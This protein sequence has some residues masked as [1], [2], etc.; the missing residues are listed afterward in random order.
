MHVTVDSY[1]SKLVNVVRG[2]ARKYFVPV[3]VPSVHLGTFIH[4]ENNLI[5][6]ADD[7]NLTVVV[8][9]IGVRVAVAESLSSDSSMLVSDVTFGV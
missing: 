3:I 7:S 5:F 4:L 6:Y 9:A 2:A 1:Q 8:P